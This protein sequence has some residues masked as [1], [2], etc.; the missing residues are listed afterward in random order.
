MCYLQSIPDDHAYIPEENYKSFGTW[1]C[2]VITENTTEY[3]D[4]ENTATRSKGNPIYL[5]K[6]DPV[7]I[8]ISTSYRLLTVLMEQQ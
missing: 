8:V 5:V 2:C 7:N 1:V 4:W 3:N 6:N